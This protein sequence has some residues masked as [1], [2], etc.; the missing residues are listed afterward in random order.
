[1]QQSTNLVHQEISRQLDIVPPIIL[2]ANIAI[3]GAG[4]I[5]SWTALAL[6]KMGFVRMTVFDFDKV[7]IVNMSSQFYEKHDVGYPKVNALAANVARFV[8]ADVIEPV[9]D[10]WNG[11]DLSMFDIVINATDSMACRKQIFEA[12]K[13]K[14]PA[15]K[16]YIDP[17]MGAET[18]MLLVINPMIGKDQ[19]MYEKTLYT[20][21]EAVQAPC[22]AKSTTYC[23]LVLSGLVAKSVSDILTSKP[24]ARNMQLSLKGNA[25]DCQQ[26]IDGKV[27]PR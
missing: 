18:A 13:D 1:M 16:A 27:L 6:A 26:A 4:A 2:N 9:D 12:L 24:Y 25:M 3:I 15:C 21:E 5:G 23:A 19:E 8:D 20:D 14:S 7:D 22:T 11:G 10:R 17:R